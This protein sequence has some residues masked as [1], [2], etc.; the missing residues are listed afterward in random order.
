MRTQLFLILLLWT[1][2]LF[3]QDCTVQVSNEV[4][5]VNYAKIAT[6]PDDP[7]RLDQAISFTAFN[8][9]NANQ[10]KLIADLFSDDAYRL[11]FCM[12]SYHTTVDRD[13]YYDVYDAFQTFSYAFRLHDFVKEQEAYYKGGG[14][15]VQT[16]PV[17]P[18][19]T[20]P[21]YANYNGVKGCA[22]PI[23]ENDFMELAKLMN[24][25]PSDDEKLIAGAVLM[26]ENCLSMAQFMKLA[27]LFKMESKKFSFMTTNYEK[28]YDR[29]NCSAA[30]Q[31]LT[32]EPYKQE[33]L[34]ICNG[35]PPAEEKTCAV[36]DKQMGEMLNKIDGANFPDDQLNV[37]RMLNKD[38]CFSTEQVRKIIGEFSF[39]ANKLDAAE[40]LYPKC[41]DRDNYY[42]LKGEFSFPT[43]EADFMDM[44]N[45]N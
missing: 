31:L 34:S 6:K 13:N 44:I 42:K 17:F 9:V 19:L 23:P 2:P 21:S 45:G 10:V 3:A 30:L 27:T 41:T 5:Q 33:W 18:K 37:V 38:H 35:N 39:P 1:A 28:V 8:C 36:N 4:F 25:Y 22:A 14:K 7:S 24:T 26:K 11:D 20:Y 12:I 43:Y 40:I 32:H 16:N 29:G 15:P